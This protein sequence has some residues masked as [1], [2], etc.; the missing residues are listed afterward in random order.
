M[1]LRA[2]GIQK[3][4]DTR[5][6]L[7]D[8]DIEIA[9]GGITLLLGT[10]GS[11]KTTLANI[12]A[13]LLSPDRGVLTVDGEPI[14]R[15]RAAAR[16]SIG[17]ASHRPLLYLGLTPLENLSFFG[18]LAGVPSPER[19]AMELLER[20]GM[21]PFARSPVERF[22]R[23]M[24]QRIVLARALLAD[25]KILILDEPYTGLDETGVAVVNEVLRDARERGAGSLVITHEPE[26]V[27][28]LAT[29][30][31]RMNAGR[32]EAAA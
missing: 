8:A 19:R 4:F 6:V 2:E 30:V 17:F 7:R 18:G 1:I 24:L 14:A 28:P 32:V 15:R 13:T 20:L 21:A 23:G 9:P 3:R 27:R 25:P 11:G 29:R 22:S 5:I 26:R 16:R 10:N 31:L 12:L